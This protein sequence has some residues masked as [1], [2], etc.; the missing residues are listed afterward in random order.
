VHLLLST[1][2]VSAAT[3]KVMWGKTELKVG[4]IGKVIIKQPTT[5]WKR[6]DNGK[7]N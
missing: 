5:L 2:S 6:L 1:G 7:G 3:Q 4:Q